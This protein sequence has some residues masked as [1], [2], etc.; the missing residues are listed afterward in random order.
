MRFALTI[1]VLIV[2]TF[3]ALVLLQ[4]RLIY[5][6]SGEVPDVSVALSGAEEVAFR[7]EDG[8]VLAGWFIAPSGSGDV[9]T[10]LVF[11]GN[12]GNRADRSELATA[13]SSRGHGV[14]LFDYRGFGENSGNPSEKGLH[15]DGLGAVE[16]LSSRVD[17][18]AERIVYFGESLGAAVAIGAAETHPPAGLILRSPFASLA[19][20]A[21]VHYPAPLSF[22]LWDAFSNSER[23]ARIHVPILVVAGSADRTIPIAQSRQVYDAAND[24]KRFVAIEGADHNERS[25]SSGAPMID[26]V[27]SFLGN[28]K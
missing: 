14:M 23:I 18:D 15:S 16:Y 27:L 21:A 5:F 28:L 3:G 6:P 1:G 8:L 2:V 24:P 11:N 22:L 26:E 20:V 9:F 17:V 7:T 12:G 4:R 25:L 19:E 10:V 13:L